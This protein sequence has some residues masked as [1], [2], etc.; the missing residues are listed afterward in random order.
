MRNPFFTQII[1]KTGSLSCTG[2]SSSKS[3][4]DIVSP[5]C[6]ITICTVAQY[7]MAVENKT[8]FAY[9]NEYHD[10]HEPGIYVMLFQEFPYSH[11]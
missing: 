4:G 10:N 11:L 6:N 5:C 8:E 3:N 9:A 1:M 7:A 2:T